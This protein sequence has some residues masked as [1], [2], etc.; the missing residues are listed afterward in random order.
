MKKK[1]K[2][3]SKVNSKYWTRTHKYGVRV[4]N[5]FKEAIE[6]NKVNGN[7]LRWEEIFQ[8]TNNV[9]IYFYIYKSNLEELPPWYQEASRH[10]IFDANT[11]DNL[12]YKC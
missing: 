7:T 6:I 11:G 3:I 8:K 10:L 1:N 12:R 5:T 9:R 4:P 2:N